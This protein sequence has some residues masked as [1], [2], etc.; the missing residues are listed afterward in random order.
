VVS[1]IRVSV[2]VFCH[3]V[4]AGAFLMIITLRN[5]LGRAFVF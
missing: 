2:P 4:Y 5:V 3:I 1:S